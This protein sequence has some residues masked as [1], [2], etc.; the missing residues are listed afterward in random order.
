MIIICIVIII[1]MVDPRSVVGSDTHNSLPFR[2]EEGGSLAC[3]KYL[4]GTL[5]HPFTWRSMQEIH[6]SNGAAKMCPKL[7][8]PKLLKRLLKSDREIPWSP[9]L[10]L[11]LLDQQSNLASKSCSYSR[12]PELPLFDGVPLLNITTFVSQALGRLTFQRHFAPSVC[13]FRP[14]TL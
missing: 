6:L 14:R 11:V 13:G 4:T 9:C 8:F 2:K 5:L 10:C 7:L 3:S 1:I 12:W